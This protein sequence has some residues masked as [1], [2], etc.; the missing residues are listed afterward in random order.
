LNYSKIFKTLCEEVQEIELEKEEKTEYLRKFSGFSDL[1]ADE[2]F[3][4]HIFNW[5]KFLNIDESDKNFGNVL[6]L[7]CGWGK[8]LIIL[9]M[10]NFENVVGVDVFDNRINIAKKRCNF[11][12]GKG[13]L[14]SQVTIIH[15]NFLNYNQVHKKKYHKIYCYDVLTHI[16]PINEALDCIYKSLKPNG[17]FVSGDL[18]INNPISYYNFKKLFTSRYGHF[19]YG[20]VHEASTDPSTK[21]PVLMAEEAIWSEKD[22]KTLAKEHGFRNVEFFY[23][24]SLPTSI[25]NKK[26]VLLENI[27]NKLP[28]SKYFG[29]EMFVR[30]TK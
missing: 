12:S 3:Q 15:E 7:G 19:D 9:S 8:D 27:I 6:D 13:N 28:L 25:F 18:N 21:K 30:M 17:I 16:H 5:L 23:P 29:R 10:L 2:L 24:F 4:K 11:H 26:F 14:N 22:Y 1:N 20:F